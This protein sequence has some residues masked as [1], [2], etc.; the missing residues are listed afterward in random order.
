MLYEVITLPNTDEMIGM[1]GM[2]LEYTINE[3]EVAY[4]MSEKE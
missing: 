4:F 2:G 3:V 1:V